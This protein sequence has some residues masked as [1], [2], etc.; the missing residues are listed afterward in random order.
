MTTPARN[1][2]TTE[3][4]PAAMRTAKRWLLWKFE[5]PTKP[6]GKPRKV[7]YYA[8]GGTR[9]AT[10]TP[11]D[12]ARLCG[13]ERAM[14]ALAEGGYSGLGFALG[15]DGNGGYWQ[16][17]DLDDVP[18]RPELEPFAA[19]LPG[20]VETSISGNGFHAIGY[21]RSFK[22]LGSNGTGVEA[23]CGGRFLVL[24]GDE[25]SGELCDIAE[26]VETEMVPMHARKSK[27]QE[28]NGA[29][30]SDDDP[31][32][33]L[34]TDDT[35]RELRSA[36]A[37]LS[38]DDRDV[39]VRLGHALKGLG[40]VGRGLWEEWSQKSDKYDATDASLAWDSFK[41][42]ATN[43]RAVFAEAQ[44]QGWP[45]TASDRAT[46]D[47]NGTGDA[48]IASEGAERL[49]GHLVPLIDFDD[50]LGPAPHLFESIIPRGE[51]TLL[52]G[53]GAAGK[54]FVALG[55]GLHVAAGLPF[56]RLAVERGSVLFFS[57]EDSAKELRRRVQRL[58]AVLGID[59]ADIRD[60]LHLLDMSETDPVLQHDGRDGRHRL[61]PTMRK[62]RALVAEL[63]PD[64]IVI[65]NASDTFDGNEIERAAVR[66][67]VR[68]LRH[69]ARPNRAVLLLAHVDKAS[70]RA[71]GQ[72][73]G[74]GRGKA[75]G[76]SYSGS[77][78]WHNSCR[79]R[80]SLVRDEATLVL[81][82]EKSNFGAL[83]EPTLLE[84]RN[85]AP[86]VIGAEVAPEVSA[87]WAQERDAARQ[88]DEADKGTIA[89]LIRR[90]QARDDRVTASRQGQHTVFRQLSGEAGFPE[91]TDARRLARLLGELLD[92]KRVFQGFTVTADRKRREVLS[93]A[94]I[95]PIPVTRGA[96]SGSGAADAPGA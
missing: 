55:M 9:G 2:V 38:S 35:K 92:E 8:D 75:V 91:R 77:T 52:A 5:P 67:F 68:N 16:G 3:V 6:G 60:R 69:L 39:W 31:F 44:R 65:D 88:R 42:K 50:D 79:S 64:L 41:P 72:A 76:E 15:A 62:L 71:Q 22:T 56:G 83:A 95:P 51:V 20:Y 53:H 46:G 24:T 96:G 85:G 63:Q 89:E 48:E 40:D 58:V 49:N 74:D 81:G 26:F 32:A 66:A 27:A 23:Y 47:A 54:S 21:G 45:N 10:D 33:G 86:I 73:K 57:A 28:P 17:V 19:T 78:A 4:L 1:I 7:P 29:A 11:R 30:P 37:W 80:L 18:S 84:F 70:A 59:W 13:L 14:Q 36:L 90:I 25:G 43:H 87:Q 93:V 12:A 34:V 94:P 61:A 82:H